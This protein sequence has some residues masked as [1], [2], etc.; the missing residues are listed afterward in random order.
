MPQKLRHIEKPNHSWRAKLLANRVV[1]P[2]Q[3][4][5]FSE[6][7]VNE[8]YEILQPCRC[9]SAPREVAAIAADNH[10]P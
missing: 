10:H 9:D 5:E 7:T 3:P 4:S 8:R 1:D 2:P 6:E